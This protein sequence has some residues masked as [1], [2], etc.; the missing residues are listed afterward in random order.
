[1]LIEPTAMV[2]RRKGVKESRNVKGVH[3]I[4]KEA[5]FCGAGVFGF[6]RT[7]LA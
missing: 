4:A 6:C 1:M 5:G 7:E 2:L 3:D